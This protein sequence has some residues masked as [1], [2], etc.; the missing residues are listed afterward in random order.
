MKK[1]TRKDIVF[2]GVLFI[3]VIQ[4]RLMRYPLGTTT[5]VRS[6]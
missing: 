5:E 3:S 6:Q 4:D 2:P 1:T